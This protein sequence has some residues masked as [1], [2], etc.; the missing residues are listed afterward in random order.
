MKTKR[1]IKKHKKTIKKHKKVKRGGGDS[2]A[3]QNSIANKIENFDCKEGNCHHIMEEL[4]EIFL[5]AGYTLLEPTEETPINNFREIEHFFSGNRRILL[6]IRGPRHF[7]YIQIRDGF[8][9]IISRWGVQHTIKQYYAD[10]PYGKLQDFSDKTISHPFTAS[11]NKYCGQIDKDI[12]QAIFELF[13]VNVSDSNT[14][15][16]YKRC[17]FN[18]YDMVKI[19]ATGKRKFGN[20][21][22]QEYQLPEI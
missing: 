18:V 2:Q 19:N 7:F 9:R 21:N 17:V 3:S 4:K 6:R 22:T 13:R 12:T 14:N 15:P 20:D 10:G 1:N 16:Y 8:F 5:K 11:F